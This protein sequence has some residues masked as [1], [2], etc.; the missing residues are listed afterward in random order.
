MSKNNKGQKQAITPREDDYAQWYQD[1]IKEADLADHS[2]V[3]GAM[4]IKPYGFAIWEAMKAELDTRIKE[5]GH[6]NMYFPM[7]IPKSYMAKEAKHVEG[8]AMESLVV[9]HHRL[10]TVEGELIV[11]P[12]AKLEEELIIRPTSET[13][14]HTAFSDWIQSWRD[15]P[16][17][18]NQWANVMRWE[19]RPRLFLRTTEFLWQEGHTAHATNEDA[20][21]EVEKML[22]VYRVFAEEWMAM[23]V[24]TGEKPEHE[25]FPG[26]DRTFTIEAMMQDGK[27]LQA[28][29]S[30]NL[31][32]NFSKAFE[33]KFADKENKEQFAWLT[34]WGVSTR[35]MGGLIMEHG[36]DKGV[37]VPPRLA[38]K[39]VVI[40]PII[41]KGSEE[42]VQKAVE[43]VKGKLVES[44][45]RA[46]IDT[47]D[48]MSLGQRMFEWEKKGVPVR[49]EIGP[50]D[51]ENKEMVMARR[52]SEEKKTIALP[53]IEDAVMKALDE[54]QDDLFA[55]AK[56][57]LQERSYR[58]DSYDEFKEKL[59]DGG[60]FYM[61]WCGETECAEAIQTETKATVRCI[62]CDEKEEDGKCVRCEGTSKKRVVFA[63]AY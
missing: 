4:I 57:R 5:T 48:H 27:A 55:A 60:F 30:H 43:Y 15:L 54:M 2:D 20:Q 47:R 42:D 46:H 53:D 25:R 63:R 40:V 31:G 3:K 14:I 29:T 41:K 17:L 38:P 56:K 37:I 62:P 24:I 21:E 23:P 32:Q 36:D 18:I 49:I 45:I 10:K 44:G 22:E 28:G 39:Q 8:F 13:V 58:V 26:A 52:D 50:R 7:L 19:M 6:E 35:L 59:E 16:V 9:T 34:S 11:D 33:V 12:E 51:V 61:H 1:V